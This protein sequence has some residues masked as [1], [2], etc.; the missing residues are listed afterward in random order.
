M[1]VNLR[2]SEVA[3]RSSRFLTSP[4]VVAALLLLGAVIHPVRAQTKERPVNLALVAPIQVFPATDAVK[5]VRLNLIYGKNAAMTGLDLGLANHVTGPVK[6]VQWGAVNLSESMVGWQ[7]GFVNVNEG[8]FEGL[9]WGTVNSTG[10]IN[11]LQ[12][13]LVNYTQRANGVQIGLIN[14]IKEG[15]FLPVMVI[16]NWGF[17]D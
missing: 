13:G 16:A 4:S 7:S 10:R 11:G 2:Q 6:G 14:I 9:Q 3:M 17:E 12:F 5:G 1:P 15:G 8:E